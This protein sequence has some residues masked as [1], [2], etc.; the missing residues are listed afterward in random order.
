MKNEQTFSRQLGILF[1]LPLFAYGIGNA[2]VES[3]VAQTE[4]TAFPSLLVGSL[5]IGLNAVLVVAIAWKLLPRLKAENPPLAVGYAVARV[6]EALLLMLALTLWIGGKPDL[7]QSL[8]Q[9]GMLSLALGSVP[10][11]WFWWKASWLPGWLAIWG[12]IGYSLLGLG[13]LGELMGW[14]YGIMLSLPGGLFE[15]SLGIFL[16]VKG[17]ARTPAPTFAAH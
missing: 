2:L 12:V 8:Y 4:T 7:Q 17:F 11:C 9:W 16:L 14:P 6:A 15:L 1:I 3:H 10:L 13:A 5:L